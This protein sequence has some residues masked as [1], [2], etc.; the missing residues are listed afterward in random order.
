MVNLREEYRGHGGRYSPSI[1]EKEQTF[2]RGS[3]HAV[4]VD[5]AI[6]QVSIQLDSFN[7]PRENLLN[8]GRDHIKQYDG[9]I[10]ASICQRRPDP[11][12]S[13]CFEHDAAVQAYQAALPVV[14]ERIGDLEV[15][16]KADRATMKSVVDQ[17]DAYANLTPEEDRKAADRRSERPPMSNERRAASCGPSAF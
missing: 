2:S 5:V 9:E 14:L 6:G 10:A 4:Q 8:V 13:H 3:V 16:L 7:I 12:L 1:W 17:A 15:T 11:A